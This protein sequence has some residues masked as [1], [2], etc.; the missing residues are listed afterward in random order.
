VITSEKFEI[1]SSSDYTPSIDDF[2]IQKK[3]ELRNKTHTAV[4][5]E[6]CPGGEIFMLLKAKKKLVPA[7]A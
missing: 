6:Y 4:G 5:L 1:P 2:I 7:E 3:F